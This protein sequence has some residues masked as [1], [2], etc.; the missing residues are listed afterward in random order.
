MFRTSFLSHQIIKPCFSKLVCLR[1]RIQQLFW[2][3]SAG[4]GQSFLGEEAGRKGGRRGL[5]KT[6]VE[7][8][9]VG[10]DMES[11]GETQTLSLKKL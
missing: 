10:G 2:N 6:A 4:S 8:P 9:R 3:T 7:S 11:V 1:N 5:E